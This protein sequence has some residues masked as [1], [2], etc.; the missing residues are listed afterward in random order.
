MA[1]GLNDNDAYPARAFPREPDAHGQAALLLVE[2]LIH[3]LIA[4]SALSV[5][6]AIEIVDCAAEVS[7]EIAA[8]CG[9]SVA[10]LR[11]SLALLQAIS[12]SLQHDVQSRKGRGS[13]SLPGK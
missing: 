4:R 8:D 11:H 12:G 1:D 5:V 2:S 10:T 9:D 13:P 6:E 3:N 7:A